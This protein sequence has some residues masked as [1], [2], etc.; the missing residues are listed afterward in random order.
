MLKS[1]VSLRVWNLKYANR[2]F[3]YSVMVFAFLSSNA[4]AFQEPQ[5]N[6][7]Q[8]SSLND[9]S[10]NSQRQRAKPVERQAPEYPTECLGEANEKESVV[11]A[12]D[13]DQDGSL[14]NILVRESSNTCFDNA[15]ISAV[16]NWRYKPALE[17]GRP[18]EQSGNA[19]RL[20]FAKP[21]EEAV[22][23]NRT[24]MPIVRIP[25]Q[26]PDKCQ[27]ESGKREVVTIGF[28]VSPKG[29]IK[30]VKVLET[31]NKCFNKSAIA[32]VKSWRYEPATKNGEPV[33]QR[34][35]ETKVTFQLA[36]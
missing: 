20:S 10:S 30:N 6:Q 13:V 5:K 33:W 29:K 28:D 21:P 7:S 23:Q 24:A 32:T 26:Y 16:K 2:V 11:V 31:T 34:G 18:V 25:P 1:L 12:F 9:D 17:D 15:A 27:S 4:F 8:S 22:D 14:K 35:M 19:T 3:L 36:D